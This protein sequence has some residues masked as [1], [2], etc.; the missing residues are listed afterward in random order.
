M[1]CCAG[2]DLNGSRAVF[3][4][5]H[6]SLAAPELA[7]FLVA[8]PKSDLARIHEWATEGRIFSVN[9]GADER[10]PLFQIQEGQPIPQVAEIL[11]TLSAKLSTWQ[12]AFWFTSPNAW[13]GSWRAPADILASE[14][15]QVVEAAQHEVA[16]VAF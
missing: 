14:P 12:I 13:T 2:S 3:F 1:E 6:Q 7:R 8:D 10:Y 16:A 11:K 5:K 15:Q 4:T 9:D